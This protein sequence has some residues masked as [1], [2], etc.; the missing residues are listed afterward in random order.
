M[1]SQSINTKNAFE[2]QLQEQKYLEAFKETDLK[3]LSVKMKNFNNTQSIIYQDPNYNNDVE[4]NNNDRNTPIPHKLEYS[5][6]AIKLLIDRYQRE[7]KDLKS[8]IHQLNCEIR[9]S[10]LCNFNFPEI[11]LSEMNNK[12]EHL[13]PTNFDF[14]QSNEEDFKK[15]TKKFSDL[16]DRFMDPEY[17]NPIFV[18]YKERVGLL[19]N[20][21]EK[22]RHKIKSL[23]TKLVDY[24]NEN[25]DIREMNILY[26]EELRKIL[27]SKV[28]K[29]D[30]KVIYSEE[31]IVQLEDR[32]SLLSREN[33]LLSINYQKITK[34]YYDFKSLFNSKFTE[35]SE[36]L[37]Q[38][39]ILYKEY[40][41]VSRAFIETKNNLALTEGKLFE[42]M[43][44]NERMQERIED[45]KFHRDRLLQHEVDA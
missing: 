26:K 31:Y 44:S 43:E 38:Y 12:T 14:K 13:F 19:E 21:N 39:N 28:E 40:E 27:S 2:F 17:L 24:A 10:S 1:N 23:E 36:K 18:I 37:A 3:N 20:E 32:N 7:I 6:S 4:V 45:L 9:K 30:G 35:C 42:V 8:Y 29:N 41:E 34:E 25:N 16:L 33:E 5:N 11:P 15:L 22:L